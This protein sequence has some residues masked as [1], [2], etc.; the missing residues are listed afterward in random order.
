MTIV[1]WNPTRDLNAM[2]DRVNR[3]F[4]D[5][6]READDDLMRRGVWVPPVDIFEA[7][8]HALVI[9]A[10]LADVNKDDIEITVDNNTLTLKGEKKMD[11]AI[12]DE[13]YHRVERVYGTFSRTFALPP[14][15]DTSKVSADYKNGVLTITLQMREEAKPKQ[16]PIDVQV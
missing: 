5:F 8:N 6:H 3:I 16:I 13:H 2:Q 1:R 10:E 14:T 12:Q 7:G 4:N 11:S 15:V 9:K